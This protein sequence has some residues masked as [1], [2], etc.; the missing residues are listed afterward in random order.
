[1]KVDSCPRLIVGCRIKNT[2]GGGNFWGTKDFNVS[3][4]KNKNGPWKTLL[5]EHLLQLPDG[6]TA[7]VDFTF[8]EPVEVQFLKFDLISYWKYGGGLQYF[9]AIPASKQHQS[10]KHDIIIK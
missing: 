5:S 7:L 1:M 8:E 4:S 2:G 10:S 3:G 6:S 9:A